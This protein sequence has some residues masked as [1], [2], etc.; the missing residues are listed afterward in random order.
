MIKLR[1]KKIPCWRGC[2]SFSDKGLRYTE[3]DKE[4]TTQRVLQGSEVPCHR[5]GCLSPPHKGGWSH[6]IKRPDTVSLGVSTW[7]WERRERE[8]VKGDTAGRGERERE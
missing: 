2:L 8:R 1:H 7:D 3:N 4:E 5:T 6:N